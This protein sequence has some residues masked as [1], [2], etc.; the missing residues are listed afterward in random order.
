MIEVNVTN[1]KLEQLVNGLPCMR[2]PTIARLHGDHG[3]AIKVA[4]PRRNL[5]ELIANI[6]R[7]GGTDIVV[8]E[9]S[10]IVA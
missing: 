6:K 7:L 5:P 2:E 4:A 9:I 10:Q 3:F 8:S 1:D